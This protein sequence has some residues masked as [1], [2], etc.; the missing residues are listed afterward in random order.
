MILS[1]RIIQCAHTIIRFTIECSIIASTMK[2]CA[3]FLHLS[4]SIVKAKF[5]PARTADGTG[6]SCQAK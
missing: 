6:D 5:T 3:L 2:L 1:S 4:K